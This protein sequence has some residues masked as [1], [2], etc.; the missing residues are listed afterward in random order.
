[1]TYL[2]SNL[3]LTFRSFDVKRRSYKSKQSGIKVDHPILGQRHVHR[4]QALMKKADQMV[5]L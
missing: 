5:V 4:D 2:I 1:M 3:H